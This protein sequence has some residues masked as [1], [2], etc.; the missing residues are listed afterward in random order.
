VVSSV[1]YV[2]HSTVVVEL[3]GARLLTDPLLRRR[4]GHLLR[5]SA[6]PE[7]GEVDAV[8][9]S[10]AHHD[11]LDLGSLARVAPDVT[12]VVPRG[13]GGVV[14]R[15]ASVIE[16][17][18][19]DEIELGAV[20]VRATHAVHEGRRA[21]GRAEGPALGYAITGSQRVYFAG[22]TDLFPEMDGLVP[23]LDVALIPIWGWGPSLGRG[24]HLDPRGA[25]EAIRLLKPRVAIPIHW[26]TY[27]PFIHRSRA[28]F[29][30]RPAAAFAEAA[31]ELAPEVEVRILQP[32]ESYSF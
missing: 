5:A 16:A 15:R 20:T 25:A 31:A 3:D 24:A 6:V 30:S 14:K 13:I 19:G 21:G 29:L 28:G 23:D 11:H 7:I 32:G 10:H 1:L 9:I 8:L 4:V 12:V 27:R 2:G 22:D 26:G 18:E 17:T